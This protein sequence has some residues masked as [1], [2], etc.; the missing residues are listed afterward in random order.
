MDE[1]VKPVDGLIFL[2]ELNGKRL[3]YRCPS[4]MI[5]KSVF[6]ETLHRKLKVRGAD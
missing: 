1:S 6:R 2:P 3:F 4:V 5:N